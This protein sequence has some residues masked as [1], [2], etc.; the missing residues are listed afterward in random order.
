VHSHFR[1]SPLAAAVLMALLA[2]CAPGSEKLIDTAG[3]TL[4]TVL[5]QQGMLPGATGAITHTLM[6]QSGTL[7]SA[8]DVS[9]EREAKVASYVHQ[10]VLAKHRRSDDK[11]LEAYL[12]KMVRWL[13]HQAG[14]DDA[15]SYQ[16]FLLEDD[17]L[18]AFTPGAG[19]VYVTTR[20]VRELKSESQMA[21]VLAHEVGHVLKSHP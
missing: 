14:A 6:G 19:R 12:T 15:M 13:A 21:M 1:F 2:S 4:G 18:N 8:F 11:E 20:L 10:Q 16:A 9:P 3:G 7:L 5:R 17:M